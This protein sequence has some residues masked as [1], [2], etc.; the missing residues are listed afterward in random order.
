MRAR[1]LK[2]V[3]NVHPILKQNYRLHEIYFMIFCHSFLEF[4]L[5]RRGV[6]ML[7]TALSYMTSMREAKGT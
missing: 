4:C 3:E 6:T 7:M 1:V 5:S 2:F